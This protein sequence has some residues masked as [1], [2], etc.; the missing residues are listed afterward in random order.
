M[1][2]LRYMGLT[3]IGV[4]LALAI[5]LMIGSALGDPAKR[6]AAY[7]GLRNQFELLRQEN[8]R[9]RDENDGAR[10]ELRAG[11]QS[12]RELLPLAVRD[13]LS[14][15]RVGVVLCGGIREGAFW[16]DLENA[17]KLAG[18]EVGPI[19]RVGDRLK[20]PEA[21]VRSRYQT[22]MNGGDRPPGESSPFDP[23]GWLIAGLA[24]GG[25]V[26]RWEELA[27]STGIELRGPASEPLRRLLVL[28]SAPDELRSA[29]VS[30][31]AI[32]EVRIIE[33]AL[34]EG[35]RVVAAEPRDSLVSVTDKLRR[36]NVATVD[37][38]D[39]AAGQIAAVLT[40]AGAQGQFGIKP[41][42]RPLPPLQP[43]GPR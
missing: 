43:P 41:G 17:L 11:E 6:D 14:G 36:M 18:A 2:D 20:E 13:K 33:A 35:V 7:E 32:P 22:L 16:A 31:G 8:Q 23:A 1:I 15:S 19:L 12:L 34:A 24:R 38:I 27:R 5:G 28:T 30:A 40:L 10:R 21:D 4:F 26:S 39:A 9:V 37:N 42:A 29:N 25:P 3:L